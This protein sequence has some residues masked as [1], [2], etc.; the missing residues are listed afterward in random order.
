MYP[1]AGGDYYLS[2]H[3]SSPMMVNCNLLVAFGPSPDAFF[4]SYGTKMS[5]SNMPQSLTN[6]FT[7]EAEMNPMKVS[8]LR[9]VFLAY[10][11]GA[12]VI[13]T[14]RIH[15][16]GRTWAAKNMYNNNSTPF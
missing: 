10:A 9:S 2:T 14:Y 15:P 16:N 12:L 3:P 13:S 8:W 11:C 5:Y 6:T 4:I 1:R 7:K